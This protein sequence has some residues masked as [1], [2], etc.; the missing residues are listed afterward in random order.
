MAPANSTTYSA[1]N[2]RDGATVVLPF[3]I[4]P[5]R[6]LKAVD[7]PADEVGVHT[8]PESLGK[9]QASGCTPG[10]G[11]RSGYVKVGWASLNTWTRWGSC[12]TSVI[13]AGVPDPE[14]ARAAYNTGQESV[15]ELRAANLNFKVML[16]K[17]KYWKRF[18]NSV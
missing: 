7:A 6:P 10:I 3:T 9:M 1:S 18:R 13:A 4:H 11:V 16:L 12:S 15:A 14:C 2:V 17:R 8:P 5:A